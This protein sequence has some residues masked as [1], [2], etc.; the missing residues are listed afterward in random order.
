MMTI[1]MP[2]DSGFVSLRWGLVANTQVMQSPFTK[3]VTT[4]G[5]TGARWKGIW[6]LPKMRQHTAAEWMAFLSALEGRQGRFYGVP[7]NRV[8]RG[9]AT[10]SPLIKGAAQVGESLVTDG[11]TPGVNNILMKGDYIELPNMETKIVISN[12]NSD[13]GGNATIPIKP[14][15]RNS[16]ADN[17]IIRVSNPRVIMMLSSDTEGEWNVDNLKNYS[18]SFSGIEVWG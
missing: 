10:G 15:L 18:I 17:G 5:L 8:P 14:A 13:G 11:W 1:A 6:T 2:K 4:L 7:S 12:V 16:P 9:A 3:S